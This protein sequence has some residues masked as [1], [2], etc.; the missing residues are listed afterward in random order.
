MY[1]Y[2]KIT[3]NNFQ[4]LFLNENCFVIKTRHET[5]LQSKILCSNYY[6]IHAC[7]NIAYTICRP[8]QLINRYRFV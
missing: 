4:F 1:I 6:S 8:I 3:F 5:D 2:L 7:S